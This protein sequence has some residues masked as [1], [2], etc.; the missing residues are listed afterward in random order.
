MQTY[1][2]LIEIRNYSYEVRALMMMMMM[3]LTKK[4]VAALPILCPGDH[5][6]FTSTLRQL[7]IDAYA[8]MVLAWFSTFIPQWSSSYDEPTVVAGWK[9]FRNVDS[10][11]TVICRCSTYRK[12]LIEYD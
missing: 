12:V 10:M 7:G 8:S 9:T 3:M 4:V 11:K 6:S 2:R 1:M 5:H